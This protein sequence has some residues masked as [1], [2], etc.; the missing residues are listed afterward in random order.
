[1]P[2]TTDIRVALEA[3]IAETQKEIGDL[4]AKRAKIDEEL[5]GVEDRLSAL[6]TVYAMEAE[7]LGVSKVPL[8]VEKGK[9][10]RF[11]GIRLI[12]A[13]A[14]IRQEHPTINKRE[15]LTILK[16]EGY[17]FRGKRPLPAVHFAWVAINRRKK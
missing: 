10:Y 14:I 12:D 1:M 15:A 17:D 8:F 9:P 3:R 13:L 2:N 11:A 5:K 6:R 4:Q 7:R 16:R